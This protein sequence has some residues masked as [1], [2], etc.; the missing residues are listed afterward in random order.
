MIE[1][2]VI[3]FTSSKLL[4]PYCPDRAMAD[5]ME[6]RIEAMSQYAPLHA[7]CWDPRDRKIVYDRKVF[8][9]EGA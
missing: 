5:R 4:F 8:K 3:A 2:C 7:L 9:L 6:C 1:F